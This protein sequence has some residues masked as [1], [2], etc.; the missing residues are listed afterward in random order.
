[1]HHLPN[2]MPIGQTVSEIWPFFDFFK[3]GGSPQ[4]WI[5]KS[6]KF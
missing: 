5:L 6:L 2:F 1:M 4:F 3:D